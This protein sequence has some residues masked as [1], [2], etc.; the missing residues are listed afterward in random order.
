MYVKLGTEVK[1]KLVLRVRNA[2]NKL[3]IEKSYDTAQLD[4]LKRTIMLDVSSLYPGQYTVSIENGEKTY[5]EKF[6]KK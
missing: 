5:K 1:G 2:A 3:A 4:A 6:I